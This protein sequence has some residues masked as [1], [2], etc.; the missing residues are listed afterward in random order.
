MKSDNIFTGEHISLP[1][2]AVG[3]TPCGLKFQA[4]HVNVKVLIALQITDGN[5]DVIDG[6]NAV[7][8]FSDHIAS[9]RKITGIPQTLRKSGSSV[10]SKETKH[11]SGRMKVR[12]EQQNPRE[13]RR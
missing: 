8:D 4:E 6:L 12:C 1:R 2:A 9:S 7:S 5:C 10:N 3:I 11:E 13:I